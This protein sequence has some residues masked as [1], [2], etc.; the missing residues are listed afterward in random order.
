[1]K[2]TNNSSQMKCIV[3]ERGLVMLNVYDYFKKFLIDQ[4]FKILL[5]MGKIVLSVLESV[6]MVK[7]LLYNIT[8][9]CLTMVSTK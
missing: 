7:Q 8:V 3:W 4:K 2:P 1:M 9:T 6:P 5:S